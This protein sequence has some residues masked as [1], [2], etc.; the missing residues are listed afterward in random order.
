MDARAINAP[1]ALAAVE[2]ALKGRF[3]APGLSLKE[4]LWSNHH[5]DLIPGNVAAYLSN[6]AHQANGARLG[7]GYAGAHGEIGRMLVTSGYRFPGLNSAARGSGTKPGQ[8]PSAHMDAR[9]ID[10]IPLDMPMLEAF[11]RLRRANL[12]FEK[13]IWEGGTW[14]HLQV[15][16]AGE[17]PRRVAY[18]WFGGADYPAFNE[19]DPRV[20]KVA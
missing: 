1:P 5:P 16:K 9:A 2:V 10:V 12:P 3:L 14:I 4:F 6:A 15:P 11:N 19:A 8:K 18:M 17:E 20:R 7:I 13:L